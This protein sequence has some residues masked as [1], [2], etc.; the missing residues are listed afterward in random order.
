MSNIRTYIVAHSIY[1]RVAHAK[2]NNI[3]T[4]KRLHAAI[5]KVMHKQKK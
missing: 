1:I 3:S 4:N 5:A 2:L